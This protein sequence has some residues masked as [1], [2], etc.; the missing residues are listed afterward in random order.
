[1]ANGKGFRRRTIIRSPSGDRSV[2]TAL[3]SESKEVGGEGGE[4][5]KDDGDATIPVEASTAVRWAGERTVGEDGPLAQEQKQPLLGS[6]KQ[7]P[8]GGRG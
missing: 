3:R 7:R 4:R 2:R 6:D 5:A 1:M 8:S